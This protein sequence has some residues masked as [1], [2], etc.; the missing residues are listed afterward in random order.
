[1]NKNLRCKSKNNCQ[2]DPVKRCV[3]DV[4]KDLSSG[5]KPQGAPDQSSDNF[6]GSKTA[7]TSKWRRRWGAKQCK[8]ALHTKHINTTPFREN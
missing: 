7:A 5:F 8:T 6:L 3:E 2:G 4:G 1:M